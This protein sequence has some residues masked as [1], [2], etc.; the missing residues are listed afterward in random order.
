MKCPTCVEEGEKSRVYCGG[1]S[2][3]GIGGSQD[4]WDEEEIHHYH[5]VN[6][7]STSYSCSRGHSW[8]FSTVPSCPAPGCE[9]GEF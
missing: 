7:V 4:F 9:W 1:S 2:M 8:V 6:R 3:T 5:E